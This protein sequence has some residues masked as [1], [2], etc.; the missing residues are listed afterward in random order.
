MKLI[1]FLMA[2]AAPAAALAADNVQ[3]SSEVF[4]ER[5][6]RDDSGKPV[7][8]LEE[9]KVVTPG[10][11][12]LFVLNYRNVGNAPATSFT[13]TN[14]MPNAV[15]YVA[16]VSDGAL[17]SVDGGKGWGPLG[18]LKITNADGTV[19]PAAPAD[20]T[21][22]RWTLRQPIAAGGQGRLSFRGSVK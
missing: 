20:V 10:D 22:V 3:L 21:H 11:R 14:P 15:T 8:K 16:A 5:E 2:L 7:I 17:V 6:T 1:A 12:L 9:P 19:R 13:V 18:A 4:V